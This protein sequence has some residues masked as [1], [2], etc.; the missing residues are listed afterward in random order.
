MRLI[1][2]NEIGEDFKGQSSA[3]KITKVQQ[4]LKD[5]EKEKESKKKSEDLEKI[6]TDLSHIWF[7]KCKLRRS[8]LC[9]R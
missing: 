9:H 5:K 8:H 3:D 1:Y 4:F 2:I 6:F 7:C